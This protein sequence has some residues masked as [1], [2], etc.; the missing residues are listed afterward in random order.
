MT[1]DY[2]DGSKFNNERLRKIFREH[3]SA[4]IAQSVRGSSIIFF[5][6]SNF[7]EEYAQWL[8]NQASAANFK[9]EGVYESFFAWYFLVFVSVQM[10]YVM[11]ASIGQVS[12]PILMYLVD[13]L[14]RTMSGLSFESKLRS[15]CRKSCRFLSRSAFCWYPFVLISFECS[16]A[17][18]LV[19]FKNFRDSVEWTFGFSQ[20]HVAM[21]KNANFETFFNSGIQS[22]K[23]HA[24]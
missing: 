21:S 9:S 4:V 24:D 12:S 15:V 7:S 5:G 11:R 2:I 6:S 23:N 18:S 17:F 3:F 14:M 13:S 16:N 1:F 19:V 8:S 22:W 10:Q 20:G